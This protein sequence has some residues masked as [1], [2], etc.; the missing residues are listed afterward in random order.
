MNISVNKTSTNINNMLSAV[1]FHPSS[2]LYGADKIL[3][4][5]LKVHSNYSSK[6]LFLPS[7]GPLVD[8]LR[9]QLPDLQIMIEPRMPIIAKKNLHPLGILRFV[10]NVLYFSKYKSTIKQYNLLYFNTL[11]VI[12]ILFCFNK[13]SI[14]VLH[15]HEILN[16]AGLLNRFVNRIALKYSDYILCVSK[17]VLNN[18]ASVSPLKFRPKLKLL[19]NGINFHMGVDFEETTF[20]LKSN[21]INFVLIGRI[22]PTHK[23][24]ILAL[25]AISKLPQNVLVN[26]HFYFVGSCVQG[27]EY[28]MYEL[29]NCIKKNKLSAFV[30]ILPF[31]KNI[32]TIYKQADVSLVPSLFE[33]PFPTTVLESM[34]FGKPVIGTNVGGIPEMIIDNVTGF[35]CNKNPD[36]IADKISYFINTPQAAIEM[37][38]RGR[39]FFEKN[40]TEESFYERFRALQMKFN[41]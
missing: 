38:K 34:F 21:T 8:L 13:A 7:N 27:Q 40:F 35:L 11:A 36:E 22:K 6:L 39:M 32:E 5:V 23:G 19:Y 16:N 26:A 33:D 10:S 2:E 9:K 28:M 20:S 31:C 4:Y 30:S 41:I 25:E 12:P 14:K 37:G 24:Q 15:V 29:E 18:L 17:A 1:F 3:T